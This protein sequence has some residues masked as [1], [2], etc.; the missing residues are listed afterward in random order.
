MIV[1]VD[2]ITFRHFFQID[3]HPFISQGFI[4]INKSKAD[5]VIR[6][7]DDGER[8]MMG[9]V[10]GIRG[11]KIYSPFSAPFG[12]FHFRNE[13]I[14]I[15]EIDIFIDSLKEY[16]RKNSLSGIEITIPPFIY[17]PTFSSKLINS[18]SRSGFKTELPEVTGWIDLEKFN[19]SFSKKNTREALKKSMKNSLNF[20]QVSSIDEKEECYNLIKDNRAKFNRPIYMSLQDIIDISE[21]WEVDFFKVID[22]Y[23]NSVAAAIFYRSHKEIIHAAFW[24]DSDEGRNL[25]AIDFLAFNMWTYYKNRGYKYI[26]VGISTEDG[27]PN[28]GL[29]RFKESH[30]SI[31]S[32]RYKFNWSI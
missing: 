10:A 17:H 30:D 25:K 6:L 29:L 13:V 1:D 15:S 21:L 7:L 22:Q 11:D 2:L 9:L 24:G 19:N 14:Y 26:D 4:E 28:E 31:S 18:L 27:I 8:K 23:N 3:P 12:G 20:L 5:K 16:I 32:L